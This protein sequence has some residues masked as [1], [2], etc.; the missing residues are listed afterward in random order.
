M[1]CD[2]HY[3]EVVWALLHVAGRMSAE[4]DKQTQ[5]VVL[6]MLCVLYP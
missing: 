2:G 6:T 1:S 4:K 3:I 5:L